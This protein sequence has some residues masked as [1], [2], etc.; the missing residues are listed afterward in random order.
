MKK[1]SQTIATYI[2]VMLCRSIL[3]LVYLFTPQTVFA[4]SPLHSICLLLSSLRFLSSLPLT[5]YRCSF[6]L[7]LIN[8]SSPPPCS[9]SPFLL[10]LLAAYGSIESAMRLD[11]FG[12]FSG[13][14]GSTEWSYS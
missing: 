10:V 8:L 11:C 14:G 6:L 13:G 3:F 4:H 9:R 2:C 5:C 7:L 1:K 12:D